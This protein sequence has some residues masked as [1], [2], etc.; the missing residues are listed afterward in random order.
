MSH[1]S[2]PSLLSH[3][4]TVAVLVFD[5]VGSFNL[6]S[7]LMV[8]GQNG[9][10]EPY[11]DLLLC[12]IHGGPV[13][14][15]S[16]SVINAS[17]GLDT[18]EQA[19]AIII[20]GWAGIDELVP[21]LLLRA[22]RRAHARKAQ[23]MGLCLGVFVLAE[24]GLLDDRRATIHWLR[25]KSF[26]KRHPHVQ[27]EAEALH[28]RDG[29][30]WT[31]AGGVAGIESCLRL[32][33]KLKGVFVAD[34][35]ARLLVAQP[36]H[37][38]P[39]SAPGEHVD[40]HQDTNRRM[41]ELL[42]WMK[43]HPHEAQHLDVLAKRVHMTIRTFTRRF[44]ILTGTTVVQWRLNRQLELAQALLQHSHA[45]IEIIALQTGFGSAL[46]LRKHFKKTLGLS[47]SEYRKKSAEDCATP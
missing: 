28:T 35:I 6:S 13:R 3:Q 33:E 46:S 15:L 19:D 21:P 39:Q 30:I 11:T 47:P 34:Q 25:A 24:A 31:C 26:A 29:N 17:H 8:F 44:R 41:S 32:L 9:I 2:N 1:S 40:T 16:G 22:L 14:T 18:L 23:I 36:V 5:G 27:L 20:P 12:T 4:P 38:E 45:T 10:Q 7:S 37:Q 42:D 43:T